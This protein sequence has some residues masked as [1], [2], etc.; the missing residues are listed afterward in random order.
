MQPVFSEDVVQGLEDHE[1]TQE[2]LRFMKAVIAGLDDVKAG[3]T[4]SVEEAKKQLG[5]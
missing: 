3:R 2:E 1:K 5:L 4:Y